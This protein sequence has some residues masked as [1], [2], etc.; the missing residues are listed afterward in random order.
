MLEKIVVE[1]CWGR[2]LEGGVGEEC[3]R[4]VW[5]RSVGEESWG[6]LLQKSFGEESCRE[7]L[8]GSVVEK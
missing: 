7:V 5:W 6:R 4:E 8:R 3:C 1:E 2:V